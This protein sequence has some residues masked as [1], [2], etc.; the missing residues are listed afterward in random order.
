M[1]ERI[2][3]GTEAIKEKDP[4]AEADVGIPARAKSR[5]PIHE[6]PVRESTQPVVTPHHMTMKP[7][8]L[9]LAALVAAFHPASAQDTAGPTDKKIEYSPYPGQEFPNQVFFGDTHL[10]TS[11]STDAGMVGCTLPPEDADR[12]AMGEEVESSTGVPARLNRPLD[13]LVV[14]DHAENPGFSPAICYAS[15]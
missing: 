7:H 14:S 2:D 6:M 9:L 15:H 11:Y 8:L 4:N 10:H 1:P 13:F 3:S 5:H 12:F